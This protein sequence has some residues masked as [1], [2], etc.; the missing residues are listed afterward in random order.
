MGTAELGD[1]MTQTE[2]IRA[3]V[4]KALDDHRS[5]LDCAVDWSG[6][7]IFVEVAHRGRDKGKVLKVMV[8]PESRTE[9]P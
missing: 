1:G 3:A 7:N 4:N 9:L 8:R 6:V 2:A 5:A